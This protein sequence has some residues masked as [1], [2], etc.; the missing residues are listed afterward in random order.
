[1]NVRARIELK[2]AFVLRRSD[3]EQIW[4]VLA[5]SFGPVKATALCADGT[6]R[7]FYSVDTLTRY[8]NS[9]LCSI[10]SLRFTA[11]SESLDAYASLHLRR[12]FSSS[13]KLDLEGP[14][15]TVLPA[16]DRLG[17]LFDGM[18]PWN[19]VS[20]LFSEATFAVGKGEGR[21]K[22]I[23]TIRMFFMVGFLTSAFWL[24]LILPF[25]W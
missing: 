7:K 15:S 2:H 14:E 13:I 25:F 20:A 3:A 16:R 9:K 5:G 23:E 11:K 4:S 8:E 21:Y 10:L 1:M 24:A 6:E 19:P 12:E 18:R 22:L 17:D